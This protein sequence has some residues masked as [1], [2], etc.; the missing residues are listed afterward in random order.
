MLPARSSALGKHAVLQS[1]CNFLNFLVGE[2]YVCV[3][4]NVSGVASAHD[5][6]REG[7][8]ELALAPE[9]YDRHELAV[10]NTQKF[11]QCFGVAIVLAKWVLEFVFL[12]ENALC[13]LRILL[14]AENPAIH[15]FR[16]D[17]EYSVSR[18]N[19][20]VNLRCSIARR[21]SD[22]VDV[23]VDIGIEEYL[24]GK[25]SLNFAYPP[26]DD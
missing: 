26:L 2:H 22:V 13:P 9:H 23:N 21:D 1:G 5:V 4:L 16:F 8:L 17:Y 25:S 18:H 10:I 19:D 20:M 7:C 12:P 14:V 24:L 3:A 6:G 11:R 15:V